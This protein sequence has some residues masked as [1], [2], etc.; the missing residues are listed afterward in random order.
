MDYPEPLLKAIR[1]KRVVPFVGAGV[2]IAASNQEFPSW[3]GLLGLLADDLRENSKNDQASE[4]DRH[5][6]SGDFVDAAEIAV[7]ELKK[8]L[9]RER[10]YRTFWKPRVRDEWNLT[11]HRSLWRFQCPLIVTTNYDNLLELTK[12]TSRT[13]TNNQTAEISCLFAENKQSPNP[14]SPVVWHIHGVADRCDSIV[15]APSQYDELYTKSESKVGELA[16]DKLKQLLVD[17]II[18]FVGYGHSDPYLNTLLEK[19]LKSTDSG[20]QPWYSLLKTK[21]GASNDLWKKY[22]IQVIEFPDYGLPFE[23]VLFELSEATEFA[24]DR[25]AELPAENLVEC[26]IDNPKQQSS[27]LKI[28]SKHVSGPKV[29]GQIEQ[30]Y[31]DTP[32]LLPR[33]RH[34]DTDDI[35]RTLSSALKKQQLADFTR[36]AGAST[37]NVD[38]VFQMSLETGKLPLIVHPNQQDQS[39]SGTIGNGEKV[40]VVNDVTTTASVLTRCVE[41]IRDAGG[42]VE[43][44]VTAYLRTEYMDDCLVNLHR[45]NVDL[46]YLCQIDSSSLRGHASQGSNKDCFLCRILGGEDEVPFRRYFSFDEVESEVLWESDNFALIADVAPIVEGHCLLISKDH[47]LSM[48]SLD[49]TLHDELQL[50]KQT[51]RTLVENAFC[52][53]VAF[54][55]G[56]SS[57]TARGGACIDHAHIHYVPVDGVDSEQVLAKIQSGFENVDVSAFA[58]YQNARDE[59]LFFEDRQ[60]EALLLQGFSPPSQ[61]MRKLLVEL[62]GSSLPWDGELLPMRGRHLSLTLL[63]NEHEPEFLSNCLAAELEEGNERLLQVQTLGWDKSHV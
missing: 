15:L 22:D 52:S 5:I 53:P 36:V 31:S 10:I 20:N 25:D 63:W 56:T 43:H 19:V 35:C 16:L 59:Y 41:E 45:A 34:R 37:G 17:K 55:H 23:K 28:A 62:S 26:L 58:N 13:L 46:K 33:G 40:L 30:S 29:F 57:S 11:L 60:P 54:E 4:A 24:R 47:V 2:S 14:E 44:I 18:L 9:F 38:F 51:A 39:M 42:T 1:D 50:A 8:S 7:E 21:Q 32:V 48:A 61:M 49:N 12:L 27:L 3:K 6:A